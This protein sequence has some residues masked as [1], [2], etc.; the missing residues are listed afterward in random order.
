[1]FFCMLRALPSPCRLSPYTLVR[2]CLCACLS[3]H[4]LCLLRVLCVS[5]VPTRVLCAGGGYLAAATFSALS[6]A[7]TQLLN[8]QEQTNLHCVRMLR[9]CFCVQ[10]NT[11]RATYLLKLFVSG[12]Y[13]SSF[14]LFLATCFVLTTLVCGFILCIDPS[15][16]T[17]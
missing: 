3:T 13:S 14:A 12:A 15:N 16:H 8:N 17:K 5:D 2:V 11:T 6:E 4:V 1:V 9:L 7:S 10:R